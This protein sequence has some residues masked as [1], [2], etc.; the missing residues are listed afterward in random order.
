M[1]RLVLNEAGVY[2]V[3]TWDQCYGNRFYTVSQIGDGFVIATDEN[4]KERTFEIA[5]VH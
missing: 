2:T 5:V 4:G 1:V 3:E